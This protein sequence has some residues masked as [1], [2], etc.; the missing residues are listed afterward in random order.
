MKKLAFPIPLPKTHALFSLPLTDNVKGTYFGAVL[1]VP[2]TT[3]TFMDSLTGPP[4][5]SIWRFHDYDLLQ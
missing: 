5:L 2:K 4:G 3:L 1:G